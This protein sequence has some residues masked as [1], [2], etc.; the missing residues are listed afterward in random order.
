M[1]LNKWIIAL[2]VTMGLGA[3]A[4]AGP[5]TG[6]PKLIR[7]PVQE[8][9]AE[10]E[11]TTKEVEVKADPVKAKKNLEVGKYYFGQK[12]W[13]AAADRFQLATRQAPALTDA[14]RYLVQSLERQNKIPETIQ[15]CMEYEKKFPGS[16]AATEFSKER[17]RL[18]NKLNKG[19]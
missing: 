11:K 8:L 15:L 12:K 19:K 16:S 9:P 1:P 10:E 13:E 18:E 2:V 5:Q 7:E 3:T 6:K 4:W 17:Q 14:W